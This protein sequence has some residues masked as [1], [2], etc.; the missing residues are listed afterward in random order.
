VEK[1]T[2]DFTFGEE[3][4]RIETGQVATQAGG[5]VMV[6]KEGLAL[7]CCATM[8]REPREGID[9][10]PLMCDY[11]ERF[12]AAGK[13]PGGFIKRE[14]RPSDTAVL[15]SRRIDRPIRPMFP[16]DFHNE[17][18]I[19]VTALS[20]DNVQVPDVYAINGASC[21]LAIS[22]IPWPNPIAAVRIG[23]LGGEYIINPT[24]PELE[25][26]SLNLLV[27]G[28]RERVNM[29]EDESKEL[30]V[31][32]VMEGIRIAHQHIVQII[33]KI[34]ALARDRAKPK[35]EYT[36]KPELEEALAAKVAAF[37]QPKIEQIIPADS[38]QDLFGSIAMLKKEVSA[39]MIEDDPELEAKPIENYVGKLIKKY[40]RKLTLQGVRVDKRGFD[41]IRPITGAVDLLPRVH[42]SA[43]FTRGQTQVLSSVTLGSGADRQRIDTV[44]F[45]EV[46][47]YVHHY[48][49]PPYSVGEVRFMRGAGRR[50]IGHGALAEKAIVPVL[51]GEDDFAYSMR[52][53]SEV[54]ES[55]ASS[56]MASTCGSSLALMAAGV[57]LKRHVGGIS[58]GLVTAEDGS[59]KLLMDLSGF[60]DFN[61]DMDFKVAGTTV[62]VTAI[63][64]DVK[65]DGLTLP[66]IEEI[67]AK[68]QT[69]YLT[70]I[71]Q[72]N[73]ILSEP[74]QEISPYAPMLML[75][76]IDV[77]QIGMVIGPSGKNIKKIIA[78]TGAQIDIDEDGKVY[79]CG[80][81]Q[82]GVKR[83]A[84]IIKAM[85]SDLEVGDEYNGR[86]V[87][88][89]NFGAFIELVP[90]RDGLLHIKD[91][92]ERRIERVEDV[93]EIGDF[94]PVKI[95]EIDSQGKI[96]LLR[97]DISYENRPPRE[98]RRS[99]GGGYG[100]GGGRGG[101]R[102]GRGGG[103]YGGGGGRGPG[104]GGDRGGRGGGG[105]RDGGGGGRDG[106]R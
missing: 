55:N 81:E 71:E 32:V 45:D 53:V 7:L 44:N 48:N 86:V 98:D 94:V 24:F 27:A 42:G 89:M 23:Y 102:G 93:L 12:Y 99:G 21:A 41:E 6:F 40:A 1:Y 46:K 47:R 18:Q 54:T 63:Q 22:N 62:G 10:F 16:D 13:F 50:E 20:Q 8:T 11:E 74:R 35:S 97:T 87:R 101:D 37:A 29:I 59:Y 91:I 103:G 90:G 76:Q 17:V 30:P 39:K 5:S 52:V 56:S 43:L 105:S 83:A 104:G 88:I 96:N 85:T 67:M 15:I 69:G 78:D 26:S 51:P 79:I 38:K 65:I 64:L 60:E 28:T 82:E 84:G 33:D 36:P 100:G 31:E 14:G 25:E 75:M 49:F 80:T 61:G 72:M 66:M 9:F 58:I 19:I 95:E 106:R 2:I 73:E 68:A 4:F 70:V 92:A 3:E 77:D 34:E 57:P